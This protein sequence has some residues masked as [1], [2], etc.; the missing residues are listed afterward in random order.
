MAPLAQVLQSNGIRPKALLRVSQQLEAATD[1][2][3]KLLAARAA[4][5][6]KKDGS[7]ADAGIA[8]PHSG[9]GV[10]E[11]SLAA[12]L[13]GQAVPQRVRGK[14]LRAVNHVLASKK[15]SAVDSR[16]LFPVAPKAEV[17]AEEEEA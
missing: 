10:S 15:K 12:A 9:R 17:A 2:D 3:A 4:K 7:Y 11:R 1:E 16:A 13:A 8:K 5:R 6:E 14:L